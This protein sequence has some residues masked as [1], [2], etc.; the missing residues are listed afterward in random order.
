MD[1]YKEMYH[2]S[3]HEPAVFWG[4]IAEEFFWKVP[5]SKDKF[6]EFNFDTRQGQVFIKWME[7]AVTNISYNVLD[8]N[9]D[10]GLGDTVA[11]YW[12]GNFP[13]DN[14][15]ITYSELLKEVC[16]FA[17]V[18]KDK[19]IKKGDRVAIYM[20]M[21]IELVVAMLACARIGAVHSIVVRKSY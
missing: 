9:L 19:G 4:E 10:K 13:E 15:Q 16:K 18:L 5:P 11:F 7:G 21:I 14:K 1:R 6:M 12:E 3:I 20:P 2:H 8:R 17:N